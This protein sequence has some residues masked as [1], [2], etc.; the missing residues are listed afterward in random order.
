MPKMITPRLN[1]IGCGQLGKTLA[2]LWAEAGLLAVSQVLN[3]SLQSSQ[4]AVEF[5]GQGQPLASINAMQPAELHLLG[6]PDK[7]LE[8][9]AAE[10][11]QAGVLRA[12]DIVFHCSGAI[13][14]E[15][16]QPLAE[17]GALIASV[18]PIKSFADPRQ[19]IYSFQPTYCGVEGDTAALAIL[20]PLFEKIG[21]IAFTIDAKQK[22]L[23]HAAS[24]LACNYL[25]ALQSLSLRAFAQAGVEESLALKVLQPIVQD[26]VANV[27][28]LGPAAALTGPIA[29]GDA[30][31][32]AKQLA[33]LQ[34][35]L[36]LEA[37]VYRLL[38]LE[39]LSLAYQ[40]QK[41]PVKDLTEVAQVLALNSGS[42]D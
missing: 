39:A 6:C 9:C 20:Q 2:Y 42:T 31:V 13:A 8:A 3:S 10:L 41:T 15:I 16:L 23:Y 25:V 11:A 24:V 27:F 40:R 14:S 37:E 5:I 12:G 18:H 1:I 36:P 21:G 22:T 19:A 26:T 34:L 38:G 33:A 32:V 35:S 30:A 4:L 29:R 17:Q 7:A 28:K